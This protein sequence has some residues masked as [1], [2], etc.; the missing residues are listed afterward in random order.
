MVPWKTDT[1]GETRKW[2]YAS[3]EEST[4]TGYDCTPMWVTPFS[5]MILFILTLL[6][7]P[8]ISEKVRDA[9]RETF[10]DALITAMVG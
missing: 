3:Q 10:A 9:A 6:S 7:A 1:V 4:R 5:M 8:N 2:L